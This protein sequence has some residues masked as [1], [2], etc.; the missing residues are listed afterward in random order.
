M[1]VGRGGWNV[2]QHDT[3][4]QYIAELE[5]KVNAMESALK[6]IALRK[7]GDWPNPQ[8]IAESALKGKK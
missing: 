4:K 1:S 8:N 5:D 2:S 3:V 7:W 6:R